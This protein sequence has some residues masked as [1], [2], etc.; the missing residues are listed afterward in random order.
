V[1]EID[2]Q[3][4]DITLSSKKNCYQTRLRAANANWMM[5]V[6]QHFSAKVRI[7][8]NHFPADGQITIT[9]EDSF[10]VD[11]A[12]AQFAVTKGQGVAVYQN[13]ILVGGGWIES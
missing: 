3:S 6:P 5:K 8:N 10:A 4:G 11:F 12:E 9:D 7:R 1:K 2:V 13:D